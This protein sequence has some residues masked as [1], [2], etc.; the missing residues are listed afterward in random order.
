MKARTCLIEKSLGSLTWTRPIPEQSKCNKAEGLTQSFSDNFLKQRIW[1]SQCRVKP[2]QAWFCRQIPKEPRDDK[3]SKH[4]NM[5]AQG[6][7]FACYRGT[8]KKSS[9]HE[10]AAL[11][12]VLDTTWELQ[13]SD[14]P[15]GNSHYR[16]SSSCRV[17][18]WTWVHWIEREFPTIFFLSI[19][20]SSKVCQGWL[21]V[22]N[23]FEVNYYLR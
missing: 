5:Q 16:K 21:K 20:I 14:T 17:D 2:D 13:N 18:P 12:S 22:S 4:L 23:G 6:Q 8:I 10:D 11:E 1:D 19:A 9:R 7:Q 15:V 3:E